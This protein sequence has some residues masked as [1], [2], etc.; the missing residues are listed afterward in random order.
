MRF[1]E[2]DQARV[3]MLYDAMRLPFEMPNVDSPAFALKEILEDENGKIL[4][5]GA[6][7]IIGEAFLWVDPK[8]NGIRRVKTVR[9]LVAQAKMEGAKAG[10]EELSAWIPPQVEPEF[11][12]ALY[13]LGWTPSMWR[14]WSV[15]L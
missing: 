6:V 13:K 14:N 15:K 10:F 1:T 12:R 2:W 7:K 4:G 11:G 3:K 9:A 8:I 5:A